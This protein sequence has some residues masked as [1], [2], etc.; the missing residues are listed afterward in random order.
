MNSTSSFNAEE[1]QKMLRS[2][3]NGNGFNRWSSIYG[4]EKLSTVRTTVRQGHAVMMDR[5]FEWLQ[6]LNL[7]DNSTVLDAGCGTGLFSIRLAG[8]GYNVKAVDIAAQMVNKSREEA[9]SK[10]VED[11]INFEVNTI[12]SVKGTYDAVVCFDVLIH[13]PAEGF[14]EA[15]TNLASLTK[16]PI[17]FTYAP[18]NRILAFQHW[19]GGFFPKKE[20]RTTIQMITD[21]NMKKAME[22]TG[23]VV[24][25]REKISF[26]FYHTMLMYAERK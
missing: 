12:E 14:I 2:Y 17:I 13:Y 10:G 18:Y 3:F 23:M 21:E 4:N 8:N 1:H 9:I 20:R 5:A 25:N 19:L 26:G 6:Q 16:G 22:Q 7:P 24:K 11:K 15:F